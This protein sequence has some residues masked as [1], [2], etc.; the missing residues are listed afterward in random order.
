MPEFEREE[1][2]IGEALRII[3]GQSALSDGSYVFHLAILDG[4]YDTVCIEMV[5]EDAAR[6]AFNALKEGAA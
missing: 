1:H 5:D 6:Q 3:L 2:L 4:D